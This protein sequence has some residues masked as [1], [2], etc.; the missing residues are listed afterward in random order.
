MLNDVTPTANRSTANGSTTVLNVP[1]P[2]TFNY[3]RDCNWRYRE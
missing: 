1:P 2:N 3:V